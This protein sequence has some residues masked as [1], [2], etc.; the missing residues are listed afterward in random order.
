VSD[1]PED[2]SNE[3]PSGGI[4]PTGMQVQLN[5]GKGVPVAPRHVSTQP[6]NQEKAHDGVRWWVLVFLGASSLGVLATATWWSPNPEISKE[7]FHIFSTV[8]AVFA[9][10]L[11]YYFAH[12]K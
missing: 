8:F 7:L 5:V 3:T 1:T 11:G 9:S 6:Y 4:V 12:K 10:S 2:F